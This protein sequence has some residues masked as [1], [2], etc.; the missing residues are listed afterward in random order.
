[1]SECGGRVKDPALCSSST[2]GTVNNVQGFRTFRQGGSE[3]HQLARI[4]MTVRREIALSPDETASGAAKD[5]DPD[6]ITLHYA[7][8]EDA[9]R[10]IAYVPARSITAPNHHCAGR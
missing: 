1:M 4:F 10:Q 8:Y 2:D 7:F 6:R 3:A 5:G 9:L